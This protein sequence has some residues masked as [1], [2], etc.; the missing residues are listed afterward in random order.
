VRRNKGGA[1]V[2]RLLFFTPGKGKET[3]SAFA[4]ELE[5][6]KICRQQI[7]E[8]AMDMSPV[9]ISGAK[10]EFGGAQLCFDRFHV[11][12][13]C[14]EAC[15]LVRKELSKSLGGLPRGA[16][17]ALRG[18]MERLNE[19]QRQLRKDLCKQYSQLGRAHAIRDF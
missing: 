14:G 17:W 18:N 19:E 8:I 7:E 15:D 5:R 16:M 6:R 2:V 13:L 1:K 4:N 12:K 11:M 9:F 10:D 3:F